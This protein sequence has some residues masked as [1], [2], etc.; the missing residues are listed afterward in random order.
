MS[1]RASNITER[2]TVVGGYL[3]IQIGRCTCDGPFDGAPGIDHRDGCGY[4]PLATLYQIEQALQRAGRTVVELPEP[5]FTS[6]RPRWSW[7]GRDEHVQAQ[8]HSDGTPAIT[9]GGRLKSVD[10]AEQ[11]ALHLL[12]AA[13]KVRAVASGSVGSVTPDAELPG[14]WSNTDLTGGATDA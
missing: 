13:R 14:M 5:N 8:L 12:A 2:I 4:E 1:A 10:D 11:T 9:I 6:N 7:W 3:C